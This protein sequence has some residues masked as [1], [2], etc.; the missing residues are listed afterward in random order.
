M[1]LVVATSWLRDS[2]QRSSGFRQRTLKREITQRND[3]D[4]ALIPVHYWKAPYLEFRHILNYVRNILIPKA[5]FDLLAHYTIGDRHRVPQPQLVSSGLGGT[6]DACRS[7]HPL[8][9][10]AQ[11]AGYVAANSGRASQSDDSASSAG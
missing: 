1:A 11:A 10:T 5:V 9:G 4:K 7:A 8:R 3:S 2:V 6:A